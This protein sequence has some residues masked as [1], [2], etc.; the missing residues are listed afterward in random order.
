MYIPIIVWFQTANLELLNSLQG[1][2]ERIGAC[3][4]AGQD[5]PAQILKTFLKAPGIEQS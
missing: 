2:Q 1:L 5:Q 3:L 4:D